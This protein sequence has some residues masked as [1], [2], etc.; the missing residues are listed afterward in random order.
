[1]PPASPIP[2]FL[3]R[4]GILLTLVAVAL[5]WPPVSIA[6]VARVP[7]FK[8]PET[9]K[10]LTRDDAT[11]FSFERF[12]AEQHEDG[13]WGPR[14][15]EDRPMEPETTETTAL[16]LLT[17]ASAGQTHRQGKFAEQVQRGL[18]YLL[19]AAAV[20]NELLPQRLRLPAVGNTTRSQAIA[21]LAIAR[22]Y[23]M[24]Q[25]DQWFRALRFAVRELSDSMHWPLEQAVPKGD[26]ATF[27]TVF[28]YK[29]ALTEAYM[30][31]IP[32]SREAIQAILQW[33]RAQP[34]D[35]DL[36]WIGHFYLGAHDFRYR[37]REETEQLFVRL[38]E[39]DYRPLSVAEQFCV[40]EALRASH[41]TEAGDAIQRLKGLVISQFTEESRLSEMAL[42]IMVLQTRIYQFS[43][44]LREPDEEF[45]L[46]KRHPDL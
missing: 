14:D 30:A 9:A 12:A 43:R 29:F 45:P 32:V 20:D 3:L 24:T 37:P 19:N 1:M 28:W 18:D 15:A 4:A 8:S 46:L 35:S 13:S 31:N 6:P 10:L 42:R 26:S 25:D 34:S 41:Y 21:T 22:L 27:E 33:F 39:L 40:A 36:A 16:V 5:R 7:R 2:S 17:F 11:V 23:S 44:P 38:T